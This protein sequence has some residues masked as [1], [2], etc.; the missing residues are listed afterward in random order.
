DEGLEIMVGLWA[1]AQFSFTGQHYAL[2]GATLNPKPLQSPRIPIWVAGG[3]PRRPPFRRA[4]HWDGVSLKS[5]HQDTR[6]WL[7]LADFRE[8]VAY[9]QAHRSSQGSFEVLMSGELPDDRQEALDK[10][11]AFQGAGATWWVEEGL[12]WSLEEF[13]ER[14]HLGPPS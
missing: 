14:I 3:W 5:V 11:H 6:Q 7:T 12:G 1:E 9:V 4:V 8:C 13:R 10:V 2:E